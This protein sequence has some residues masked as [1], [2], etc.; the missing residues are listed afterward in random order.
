[1]IKYALLKNGY[2]PY[3]FEISHALLENIHASRQY[4]YCLDKK[5]INSFEKYMIELYNQY[6]FVKNI[7]EDILLLASIKIA[8]KQAKLNKN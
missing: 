6:I 4:V 8:I 1:M 7:K 2:M 5:L 3:K